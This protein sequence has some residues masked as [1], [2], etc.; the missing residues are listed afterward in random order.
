MRAY[1]ARLGARVQQREKD[2]EKGTWLRAH[3]GVQKKGETGQDTR[4]MVVVKNVEREK[5]TREVPTVEG[6]TCGKKR[7]PKKKSGVLVDI[8]PVLGGTQPGPHEEK[9]ENRST[10]AEPYPDKGKKKERHEKNKKSKRPT[11]SRFAG[12]KDRTRGCRVDGK[13]ERRG[14]TG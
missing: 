8:Q 11:S 5:K 3:T 14:S 10:Q 7:R 13:D 12:K 2:P 9:I 4:G 6:G 1:K